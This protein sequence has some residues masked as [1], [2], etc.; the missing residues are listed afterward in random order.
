MLRTSKGEEGVEGVKREIG[1]MNWFIL[2]RNVLVHRVSRFSVFFERDMDMGVSVCRL[3]PSCWKIRDILS[4][5]VMKFRRSMALIDLRAMNHVWISLA[6][7]K[8]ALPVF[9]LPGVHGFATLLY[10]N[11]MGM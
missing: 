3:P 6:V 5:L 8:K 4:L 7:S 1:S 2:R 10:G 9:L 11:F